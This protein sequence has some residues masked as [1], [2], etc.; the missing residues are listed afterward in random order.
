MDFKKEAKGVLT[1]ALKEQCPYIIYSNVNDMVLNIEIKL[2]DAYYFGQKE[3]FNSGIEEAVKVSISCK[4]SVGSL[5]ADP[6]RR[7][8]IAHSCKTVSEAILKLKK[9]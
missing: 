6:I 1:S 5:D 4:E 3:G 9:D 8:L 7:G 2:R